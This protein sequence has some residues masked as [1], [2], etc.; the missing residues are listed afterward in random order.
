M[1][2]SKPNFPKDFHWGYATASA[3]V[4][5][6]ILADGKELSIWDTFSKDPS[7]SEDGG[8]TEVATDF[9]NK[10]EED[11]RLMKSFGEWSEV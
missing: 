10:Y 8:N 2:S 6:S 5:G 1:P 4:E 7:H 3:Q 11:V 9:Y